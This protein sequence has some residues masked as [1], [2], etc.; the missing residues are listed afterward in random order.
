MAVPILLVEDS[1]SDAAILVAALE[2]SGY[3][4][5]V[6]VVTNGVDAIQR[7]VTADIESD[8]ESPQ[9]ILLDLNLPKMSGLE[10]LKEVKQNPLW[11]HIPIVVLSSSSSRGDVDRSYELHANAYLSKP[12]ELTGY[13]AI[14][15]QLHDF[16][17]KTVK[18]PT[19]G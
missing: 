19:Y 2:D 16:W 9:L 1:P 6:Q 15:Q 11:K 8:I 3:V 17:L 12:R 13:R 14:A 10:V 4:G 7:L 18:L 5:V